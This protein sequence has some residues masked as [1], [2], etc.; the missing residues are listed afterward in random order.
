MKESERKSYTVSRCRI[1]EIDDLID[2]IRKNWKE[3]HIL[4]ESKELLKWQHA[5][6][7][8][9]NFIIAR[10]NTSR[11]VLG[12]FGYIP[13]SKFDT[14]L[15]DNTNTWGAIWK[16]VDNSPI[17]LGMEIMQFFHNEIRPVSHGSI[18][19]SDIA[20]KLYKLTRQKT[21]DIAQYY[22]LS[23]S[24]PEFNIARPGLKDIE[25]GQK[26]D[27]DELREVDLADISLSHSYYPKK[28]LTYLINR[29]QKHP[30]YKYRFFG[31]YHASALYAIFVIR[32]Q[33]A[34]KESCL[35]IV[36]IYGDISTAGR[37]YGSLQELLHKEG[38]EYLDCLNYGIAESV[39]KN[40]GFQKLDPDSDTV[41]PDYFEPFER[42]N[43]QTNFAV[44]SSFDEYVIFKGDGDRDRPSILKFNPAL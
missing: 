31:A 11:A 38:S 7:D 17:G 15:K 6:G 2:F 4:A 39:F 18:G 14:A 37:I 12:I 28:S 10:D 3:D 41:I 29:Y 21:G 40:M 5:D 1:E 22:I 8:H 42:R 25:P 24:I 30:I 34:G 33:F 20:Q 23:D 27:S 32:K 36:D 9:L 43:V 26:P 19:N 16:V 44:K 35:R 13:T